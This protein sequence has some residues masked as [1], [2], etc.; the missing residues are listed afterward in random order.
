L[1]TE[2]SPESFHVLRLL[3]DPF[4]EMYGAFNWHLFY[5]KTVIHRRTRES[6]LWDVWSLIL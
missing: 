2:P 3:A 5:L 6:R 4:L 1:R